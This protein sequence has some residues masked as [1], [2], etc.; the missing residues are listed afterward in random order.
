MKAN[1]KAIKNLI[2]ECI[3]EIKEDNF[4]KEYVSH[5]QN[6]AF[7]EQAENDPNIQKRKWSEFSEACTEPQFQDQYF[8]NI[9]RKKPEILS[10]LLVLAEDE[11]QL[12]DEIYAAMSS[13]KN[14]RVDDGV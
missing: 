1:I 7:E 9:L 6:P 3:N 14:K 4:Q 10:S 5:K 8:F 12:H 2:K 11:P 13:I